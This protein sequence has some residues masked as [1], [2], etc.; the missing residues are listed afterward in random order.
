MSITF[1]TVKTVY[2]NQKPLLIV[3]RAVS[4]NSNN[5]SKVFYEISDDTLSGNIL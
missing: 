4:K 2:L 5:K 3:R 1:M